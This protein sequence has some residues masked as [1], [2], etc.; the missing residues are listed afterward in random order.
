MLPQPVE[1]LQAE[2]SGWA[3]DWSVEDSNPWFTSSS[4]N[5]NSNSN[6]NNNSNSN[7]NNNG[8]R[9]DK[10]HSFWEPCFA[11]LLAA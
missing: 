3:T 9:N 6:N 8:K 1:I 5:S 10:E 4:S 11:I 2:K 7:N